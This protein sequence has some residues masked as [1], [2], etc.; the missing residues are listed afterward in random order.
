[1]GVK[2]TDY[3]PAISDA[4]KLSGLGAL[5]P[6]LKRELDFWRVPAFCFRTGMRRFYERAHALRRQI[7]ACMT[8]LLKIELPRCVVDILAQFIY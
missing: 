6:L 1:M 5:F 7:W 4:I 3:I 8:S 2:I